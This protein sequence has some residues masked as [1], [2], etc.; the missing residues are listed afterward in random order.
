MNKFR[1]SLIDELVIRV[2]LCVEEL[3]SIKEEVESLKD[4]EEEY[5]D[6]IPEN[7]QNSIRFEDSQLAIEN[8]E[9]SFDSLDSLIDLFPDIVD[10]A[11]R[12]VQRLR[13]ECDETDEIIS[14][15][16][17]ND[18]ENNLRSSNQPNQDKRDGNDY[19]TLGIEPSRTE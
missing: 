7:L 9:N 14:Q 2:K 3:E 18:D 17:R 16:G 15:F 4:I 6:N 13:S 11:K 10:Y 5:A 19:S 8:L 12:E 1:R